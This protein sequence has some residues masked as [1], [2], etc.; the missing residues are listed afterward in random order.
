MTSTALISEISALSDTA[1]KKIN[2][3]R[4]MI[5]KELDATERTIDNINSKIVDQQNTI[6][7][8]RNELLDKTVAGTKADSESLTRIE[9]EKKALQLGL[10]ATRKQQQSLVSQN[11][12]L[13]GKL[14][15]L[16]IEFEKTN[17]GNLAQ[18]E[19]VKA[20]LKMMTSSL[21]SGA[22]SLWSKLSNIGKTLFAACDKATFSI[23]DKF[24][25]LDERQNI[26]SGNSSFI[27]RIASK[28][29]SGSAK[30]SPGPAIPIVE[31]L[32]IFC[33][34]AFIY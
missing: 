27:N 7:S 19:Q 13:Q 15:E 10:A 29:F 2:T 14:E 3:R 32:L 12:E 6:T 20:T 18:L 11:S 21:D 5:T 30:A 26:L 34:M 23:A 22:E 24:K 9:S 28:V 4:A 33:D 17:R 1:N 31:I 25:P 8:L 16:H